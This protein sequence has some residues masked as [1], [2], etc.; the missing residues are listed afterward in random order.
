MLVGIISDTHD[1]IERTAAAIALLVAQGAKVL[2][3]CGDLTSPE[4][5]LSCASLPGHYVLG[6][7]DF[8]EDELERA[9]ASS[10]GFFHG[11][12][13]V[14]L[15]DGR[16]IAITHGHLGGE[17]NRLLTDAP[18]Y[19][20]YGHSHEASDQRRGPT[21]RINPGALHRCRFWT[22]A[23]LDTDH[24]RLKFFRVG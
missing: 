20:L 7:N 22:V 5:V 18:D 1:Q 13:G 23:L 2:F 4:V 24:D 19:L 8:D 16:R 11:V 10:G 12:G 15:I 3:H 21:R 17:F 9:I 6:N 14:V